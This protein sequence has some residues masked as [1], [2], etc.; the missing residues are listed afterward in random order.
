VYTHILRG[1]EDLHHPHTTKKTSQSLLCEVWITHNKKSHFGR[2]K[3]LQELNV[4]VGKND[5]SCKCKVSH[6]HTVF[7]YSLSHS[8]VRLAFTENGSLTEGPK[9]CNNEFLAEGNNT[10][11]Q[12]Y[13]LTW[14]YEK[15]QGKE[16][17]LCAISHNQGSKPGLSGGGME[18]SQQSLSC[19]HLPS[20]KA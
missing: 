14:Y 4:E 11:K 2:F 13:V 18:Q 15:P 3:L 10:G 17:L 7:H 1:F 12:F 5:C 9:Q 6:Y 19:V 20:P 8:A 16:Q